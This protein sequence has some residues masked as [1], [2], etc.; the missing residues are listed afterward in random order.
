MVY[1]IT[2]GSPFVKI[3]VTQNMSGRLA[4]LQS[5]NPNP[6]DVL[7]TF[8]TDS[9]KNDRKLEKCIH[10]EFRLQRLVF[11]NGHETEWF[12]QTV[13]VTLGECCN[14]VKHISDKYNLS[15]EITCHADC[16]KRQL[17]YARLNS[18]KNAVRSADL[19]RVIKKKKH[20]EDIEEQKKESRIIHPKFC[21]GQRVRTRTDLKI[22]Q[23]YDG[24]F[25]GTS[26]PTNDAVVRKVYK[27][28]HSQKHYYVLNNGH[29][30][31]EEMLKSC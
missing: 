19:Y 5:G 14:F 29:S 9:M 21:T 8:E 11:D 7:M 10:N 13:L 24:F 27:D 28:P 20:D 16:N 18:V 1:V 3:G 22:G 25:F 23:K 6:L 15:F 30:Y 31:T 12:D 17:E 2:D 4:T 26:M